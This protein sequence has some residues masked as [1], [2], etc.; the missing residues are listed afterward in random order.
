MTS[1][2]LR[3]AGLKATVPRRKI[4]EVLESKAGQHLTAEDVYRLLLETGEDVGLATVYRVLTQFEGAGL[5]ERHHFE[6]GQ[7]VFELNQGEHHD[8]ILCVKCGKV[9]EFVDNIIE[10]RQRDIAEKAGYTMTGHCLYIYGICADCQKSE[11]H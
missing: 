7:S 6:G 4:L 11:G 10:E 3:A 8:H 1:E 5:V 9:E 2:D